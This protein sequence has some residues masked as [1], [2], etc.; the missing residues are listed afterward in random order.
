QIHVFLRS[1]DSFQFVISFHHA[2]LDGWSRAALTT[3]LYNRYQQ[4]LSGQALAPVTAD[5]TY[6]DF[7][8]LEQSVIA[9]PGAKAHFA[10]MLESIPEQQLPRIGQRREDTRGEDID[11]GFHVVEALFEHS[12][13]L[14]ALAQKLGVPLQAVLL[15]GHYKVLSAFSGSTSA[16]TCVTHN[17]RPETDKA[18]RGLGLFLNSLPL[19]IDVESGSWESLIRKAAACSAAAVPYRRYPM[20]NVQQDIGRT[21]ES[22]TFN[23]TH[24]HVYND[25]QE[26]SGDQLQVLGSSGFERTNF[27]LQVDVARSVGDDMLRMAL[28][29]DTGAFDEALIRRIASY[30]LT[31][32]ERML[33]DPGA[34]HDGS[35]LLSQEE[36]IEL[37]DR[38]NATR[39]DYLREPI[40]HLFER[41]VARTPSAIAAIC[42]GRSISYA[43]L[44]ERAGRLAAHLR[45]AGLET[46]ERVG[47]CLRRSL[48]QLIG[49]LGVLKAGG[50][51]VPLEP[52]LPS[53]RLAY[54]I[55]DADV[56]RILVLSTGREGLPETEALIVSMDGAVSDADWLRSDEAPAVDAPAIRVDDIAYVLYTS[57]STGVPKGVTV[58]HGALSNYLSHAAG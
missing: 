13:G 58:A 11:H 48:E 21:L 27:D 10:G 53:D 29:Y 18:D 51:Y 30:Y 28:V 49:L 8:A 6:R 54:M 55:S 5:W 34:A 7:V 37:R 25:M 19:A 43:E 32:Y 17:G 45:Q 52:D 14:I 41:Q 38:R 23:Y 36:L 3:V 50:S 24:F 31:A 2:V 4:L 15:A 1:A 46:G 12:P 26:A 47:L 44:D 39:K 16:F 56:R 40:H 9:D 20:L 57:G 35:P 42:E 22:V 33:A